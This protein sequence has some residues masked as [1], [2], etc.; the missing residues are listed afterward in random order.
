M[1]SL[2]KLSCIALLALSTTVYAGKGKGKA[3]KAKAQTT[4]KCGPN[5]PHPCPPGCPPGCCPK[6]G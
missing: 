5:C 4:Q 3:T 6:K 2:M 1:K